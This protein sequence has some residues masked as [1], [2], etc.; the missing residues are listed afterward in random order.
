M[1]LRRI[2]NT[3]RQLSYHKGYKK[4]R[5]IKNEELKFST[6]KKTKS[7]KKSFDSFKTH[8]IINQATRHFKKP[9]TIE[10]SVNV[11][12]TSGMVFGSVVVG[13]ILLSADMNKSWNQPMSF[14]LYPLFIALGAGIGA[15]AV[16]LIVITSPVWAPCKIISQINKRIRYK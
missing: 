13:G 15:M 4:I 11:C 14:M 2:L 6:L 9:T 16:P 8:P 1:F 10:E 5:N 12:A 7:F 3:T